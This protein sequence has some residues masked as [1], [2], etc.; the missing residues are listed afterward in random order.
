MRCHIVDL[1]DL[2]V[3]Y[4]VVIK[5]RSSHQSIL[6]AYSD[7]GGSM[8]NQW[9]L[10]LTLVVLLGLF[11]GSA[12][13]LLQEQVRWDWL[14]SLWR[15]D[16]IWWVFM[17]A[18]ALAVLLNL[19]LFVATPSVINI[20]KRKP[21]QSDAERQLQFLTAQQ[22]FFRQYAG[23]LQPLNGSSGSSELYLYND[24]GY[25]FLLQLYPC[26]NTEPG[27]DQL[28]QLFQLMLIHQCD[29]ALVIS[30][31]PMTAQAKIFA[32]EAN[33]RA[34]D[35]SSLARQLGSDDFSTAIC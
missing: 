18:T 26:L 5:S 13:V 6:S 34:T 27:L 25:R 14:G 17:L 12:Y 8:S 28:C 2:S 30:L 10:G 22:L 9:M 20:L 24:G 4:H 7:L 19:L 23:L 21:F 29:G 1:Y 31:Q 33:I 11:S 3:F 35:F 16:W 15:A 32:R